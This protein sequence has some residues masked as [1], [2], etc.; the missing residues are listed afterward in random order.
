MLIPQGTTLITEGSFSYSSTTP[1]ESD[2]YKSFMIS[3]NVESSNT[4][5]GDRFVGAVRLICL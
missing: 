4:T 3:G 1:S 2:L 5:N